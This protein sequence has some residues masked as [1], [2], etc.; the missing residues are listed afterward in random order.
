VLLVALA[1]VVVVIIVFVGVLIAGVVVASNLDEEWDG[2]NERA[3][4]M[5]TLTNK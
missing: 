3:L 2:E 4:R 5:I 1:E